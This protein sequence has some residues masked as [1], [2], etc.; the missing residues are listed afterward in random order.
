M[1]HASAASQLACCFRVLEIN[2]VFLGGQLATT[3]VA[4]AMGSPRRRGPVHRP[5][6]VRNSTGIAR[7]PESST[8]LPGAFAATL[9]SWPLSHHLSLCPEGTAVMSQLYKCEDLTEREPRP[10]S[11]QNAGFRPTSQLP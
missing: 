9:R 11:A 10:D 1:E 3:V 8:G 5:A 6:S 4:F 7:E 2:F